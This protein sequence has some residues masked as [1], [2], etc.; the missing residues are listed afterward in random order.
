MHPDFFR[1]DISEAEFQSH[2]RSNYSVGTPIDPEGIC[3]PVWVLEA[4]R[5]NYEAWQQA[6]EDSNE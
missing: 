2:A 6:K 5:M 3:H 1:K 4:A